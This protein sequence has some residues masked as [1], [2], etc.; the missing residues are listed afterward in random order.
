MSPG[1]YGWTYPASC[2]EVMV[3][4]P[5]NKTQCSSLP[6]YFCIEALIL[7]FLRILVIERACISHSRTAAV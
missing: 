3:S 1:L 5:Q 2:N 4:T 6:P 7:T